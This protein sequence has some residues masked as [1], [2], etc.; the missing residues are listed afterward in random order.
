MYCS[1]EHREEFSASVPP[2]TKSEVERWK[3]N[4]HS[5]EPP[6]TRSE[7]ENWI[8]ERGKDEVSNEIH[9]VHQK[10]AERPEPKMHDEILTT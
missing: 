1:D 8:R 7:L 9:Y 5:V 6:K 10:Y 4:W 2:R 3:R